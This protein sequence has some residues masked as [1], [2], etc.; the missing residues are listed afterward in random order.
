MG[1]PW[2]T[3]PRP[4]WGRAGRTPTSLG[5][6]LHGPHIHAG[7]ARALIG[8]V[9]GGPCRARFSPL[10]GNPLMDLC[11]SNIFYSPKSLQNSYRHCGSCRS[12]KR[13]INTVKTKVNRK[14]ITYSETSATSTSKSNCNG[15]CGC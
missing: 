2:A 5:L 1:R 12:Q 14:S 10:G 8:P 15:L 4:Y 3:L 9:L 11:F 6:A 13:F 7:P